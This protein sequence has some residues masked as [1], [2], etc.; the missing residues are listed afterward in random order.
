MSDDE[1]EL[2]PCPFCG[3]RDHLSRG[4]FRVECCQCNSRGPYR[5]TA[6][7][8][9]AA[10]NERQHSDVSLAGDEAGARRER[11]EVVDF[12]YREISR[13]AS[14]NTIAQEYLEFAGRVLTLFVE[15]VKRGEHG[16]GK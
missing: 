16:G 13:L 10:W 6:E 9:V 3:S 7:E 8:A 15:A 2:S 1:R 12:A 4:S 14:E 5:G 11:S